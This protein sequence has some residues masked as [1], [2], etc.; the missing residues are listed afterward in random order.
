[1]LFEFADLIDPKQLPN[2]RKYLNYYITGFVDGEGCF[3]I[4]IKKQDNT[5]FG[6]VIDPVF[7]VTQSKEHSI[8]LEVIKRTLKCGRIIPKPGQEDKV[9]QYTVDSRRSLA[10]IIIPFFEKNKPIAKWREFEFF[11]EIV[12]SLEK[13]E[14]KT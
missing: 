13:G 2:R 3:S 6:W 4:S 7:H 10:E 14:H 1:M 11:K 8:I 9:L 5:R 12:I